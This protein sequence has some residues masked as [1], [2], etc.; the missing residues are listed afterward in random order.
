MGEGFGLNKTSIKKESS[1]KE[2]PFYFIPLCHQFFFTWPICLNEA[3]EI[4]QQPFQSQAHRCC[5]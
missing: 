3:D 2:L 1:I 4:P 5:K